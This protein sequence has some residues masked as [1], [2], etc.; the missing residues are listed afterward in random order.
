MVAEVGEARAVVRV[1]ATGT[2]V[3]RVDLSRR[4]PEPRR[5]R[6]KAVSGAPLGS[7]ER[8]SEA[9]LRLR[10]SGRYV[11]GSRAVRSVRKK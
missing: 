3:V 10:R 4:Q 11:P 1:S 7:Q 5:L 2:H 9:A 8:G 6:P